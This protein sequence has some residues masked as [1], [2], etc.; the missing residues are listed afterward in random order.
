MK[1]KAGFSEFDASLTRN[2]NA[3]HRSS[4]MQRKSLGVTVP[5]K[6]LKK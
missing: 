3:A 2:K 5:D 6:V 4:F 1:A